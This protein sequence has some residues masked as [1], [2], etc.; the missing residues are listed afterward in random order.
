[1]KIVLESDLSPYN[2]YRIASVARRV[3]FPETM[4]E[5]CSL[6]SKSDGRRKIVLGGGSNVILSKH[7]YDD[8]DF[9]ILR[10][11]F[12][13]IFIEGTLM[14]AQ[15]GAF[16]SDMVDRGYEVG[17]GGLE[18]YYDIPGTIGGAI[19]MNAGMNEDEI[20][21]H[22]E[23]VTWLERKTGEMMSAKKDALKWGYRQSEFQNGDRIVLEA[24]VR[25]RPGKTEE[26]RKR[27]DE[28]VAKRHAKQP[29]DM[30]SAGSVFKRPPGRFVGQMI[31]ELGLKGYRIGGMEISLKHAGFIVNVGNGTGADVLALVAYVKEKVR[32]Q[33]GV[34]LELE[35][36]II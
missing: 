26:F 32:K 2:T 14:T 22:L 20:S 4:E 6:F 16:L 5:I 21:C 12:S 9:V 30:P 10:E 13:H 36:V 29:W 7:R 11:N 23:R 24:A 19:V 18:T 17:L 31:E 33:Y 1:M 25:L 27:R 15:A 35:Q 28:I 34:E 8:V 3:F